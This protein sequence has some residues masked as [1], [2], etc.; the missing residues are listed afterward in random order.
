MHLIMYSQ[1][2]SLMWIV[3]PAP[4]APF[5]PTNRNMF[6]ILGG[7]TDMYAPGS[8][9]HRSSRETPSWPYIGVSV[10]LSELY[11]ETVVSS[12]TLGVSSLRYLRIKACGA[13]DSIHVSLRAIVILNAS[14]RDTSD[15]LRNKNQVI[16]D[17]AFEISGSGG[18]PTAG[19]WICGLQVVKDLGFAGQS[20]GHR[21]FGRFREGLVHVRA[22]PV[23]KLGVVDIVLHLVAIPQVFVGMFDIVFPFLQRVLNWTQ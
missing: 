17:Q 2:H 16:L 1:V 22:D 19:H 11:K 10:N 20:A 3:E 18:H 7:H 9:V 13:D 21:L 23:D 6:G 4:G 5:G 15:S 12:R 8:A 14:L